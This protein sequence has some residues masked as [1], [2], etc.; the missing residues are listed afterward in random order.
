M[1][2]DKQ[3][4]D[5]ILVPWR[6]ACEEDTYNG[7]WNVLTELDGMQSLMGQLRPFS[8]DTHADAGTLW[9]IAFTRSKMAD[10]KKAA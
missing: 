2:T 10:E 1:I 4:A 3:L 9:H 8:F 7:W 6:I 5:A